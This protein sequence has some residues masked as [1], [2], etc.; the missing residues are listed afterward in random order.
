MEVLT[1]YNIVADNVP[2]AVTIVK[3]PEEYTPLYEIRFPAIAPATE[4]VLNSIKEKLIEKVQIKISEILDPKAMEDIKGRFLESA[5]VFI[6][7]TL[8]RLTQNEKDILAGYLI[9]E[10]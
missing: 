9:H 2:G 10:M 7:E 4:A 3:K 8:P 6:A 5:N 1:K